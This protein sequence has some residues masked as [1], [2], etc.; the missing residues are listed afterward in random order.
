MSDPREPVTEPTDQTPPI[1]EA[2][3]EQAPVEAD[4]QYRLPL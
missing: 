3:S 1:E 4:R 2:P